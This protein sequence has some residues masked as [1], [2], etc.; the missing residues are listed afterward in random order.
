[1]LKGDIWM[2]DASVVHAAYNFS[3][4]SRVILCLD[5][6]YDRKNVD[7]SLIFKDKSIHN[8]NLSPMIFSRV[9][10]RKEDLDDFVYSI[11]HSINSFEDIKSAL[12]K[13]SN[14]HIH[15]DISI[16]ATYD[17]LLEVTKNKGKE[18]Y[19]FCTRIKRYYTISRRFG[20]RFKEL[21]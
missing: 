3:Q 7:P 17:L 2:L 16:H 19:K 20:E 9:S 4:D 21:L 13:I 8:G 6:Q 12:L 11:S 5:F 1:M 18:M 15:H 10:L 14:A